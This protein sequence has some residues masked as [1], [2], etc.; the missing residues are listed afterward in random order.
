MPCRHDWFQGKA[1]CV[2]A[3]HQ[4][5]VQNIA[6]VLRNSAPAL[7]P[8]KYQEFSQDISPKG[9]VFLQPKLPSRHRDE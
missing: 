7:L 6:E 9:N 5:E 8:K 4:Q 2:L 3:N 1:G